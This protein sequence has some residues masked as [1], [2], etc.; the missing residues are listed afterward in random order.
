HS[1][2]LVPS[3]TVANEKFLLATLFSFMSNR[4]PVPSATPALSGVIFASPF[5]PNPNLRIVAEYN[6]ESLAHCSSGTG[7]GRRR[8]NRLWRCLSPLPTFRPRRY[9]HRF[10]Q[11]I[12]HHV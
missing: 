12:G 5:F 1:G 2:H 10:R 4:A 11:S 3:N 8:P 9:P 6:H 7:S